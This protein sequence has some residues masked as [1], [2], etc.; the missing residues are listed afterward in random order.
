[1]ST[2]NIVDFYNDTQPEPQYNLKISDLLALDSISIFRSDI[3]KYLFPLSISENDLSEI[4]KNENSLK[5]YANIICK[6]IN[7]HGFFYYVEINEN[8][9]NPSTSNTYIS[10]KMKLTHKTTSEKNQYFKNHKYSNMNPNTKFTS[11]ILKNNF[12]INYFENMDSFT[13]IIIHTNFFNMDAISM[14]TQKIFI[15]LLDKFENTIIQK[16]KSENNMR[17]R[18]TLNANSNSNSEKSLKKM[19]SVRNMLTK[20]QEKSIELKKENKIDDKTKYS[21]YKNYKNMI[22]WSVSVIAFIGIVEVV[23]QQVY[24]ESAT[25]GFIDWGVN[26]LMNIYTELPLETVTNYT[27]RAQAALIQAVGSIYS[28]FGSFK[29][30][31]LQDNYGKASQNVD[32]EETSMYAPTA[33]EFQSSENIIVNLALNG[34]R[35]GYAN[36]TNIL[37]N[38][39][40]GNQV[41]LYVP[42]T[43]HMAFDPTTQSEYSLST[44]IGTFI[45]SSG[46]EFGS[47]GRILTN[48]GART[49]STAIQL[50]GKS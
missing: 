8:K 30:L 48:I 45:P 29:N 24:D 34:I 49:A 37:Q 17:K 4:A 50:Y 41:A 46:P 27:A 2:F 33:Q 11:H 44:Q 47:M 7:V 1:M 15:Y 42:N 36:A 18:G 21:F 20:L 38:I 6:Y 28:I 31:I 9:T 14:T 13:S 16:Q 39:N 35:Q 10:S 12:K 32:T 25:S 43:Q 40:L 5:N 26:K 22:L 23:G 19:T 3:S